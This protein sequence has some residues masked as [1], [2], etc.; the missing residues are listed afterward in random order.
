MIHIKQKRF[1]NL[2]LNT[3]RKRKID[4]WSIIHIFRFSFATASLCAVFAVPFGIIQLQIRKPNKPLMVFPL[5]VR[6]HECDLFS[7]SCCDFCVLH[8]KHWQKPFVCSKL[9]LPRNKT[10]ISKRKPPLL[11]MSFTAV[12]EKLEEPDKPNLVTIFFP[13]LHQ[14]NMF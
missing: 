2:F 6:K 5:A 8:I 13:Q 14:W 9:P 1:L 12:I 10:E 4:I 3:N 7:L 11:H